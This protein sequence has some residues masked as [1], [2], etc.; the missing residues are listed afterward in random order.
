[1][2]LKDDFQKT[3]DQYDYCYTFG[4]TASKMTKIYLQN[5]VPQIFNIVSAPIKSR[6]VTSMQSRTENICGSSSFVSVR[7]QI[8]NAMKVMRF[9]RLGILFNSKERNANIIHGE[10]LRI[11]KDMNFTVI[12]LNSPS[13]TGKLK[14]NLK[15]LVNRSV[16]VD[17]VYLPSDSYIVSNAGLVCK[18]LNKAGIKTIGA[19]R[20]FI[21]KGA[22]MGTV[23]NYFTLGQYAARI[24][25]R[26][27]K[28]EQLKDIPVQVERE[29]KLYINLSTAKFLKF[30]IDP[31]IK[32]KA[33]IAR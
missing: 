18:Q 16:Q 25:D 17:A 13:A 5:R 26:N 30:K 32:R 31:E 2:F 10:L 24:I 27:Q 19:L 23:I 11:A 29:P 1:M 12:P 22:L 15:K 6:L 28:G 21:D 8:E 3:M 33:V 4:A 9:K 20:K 14:E 7:L